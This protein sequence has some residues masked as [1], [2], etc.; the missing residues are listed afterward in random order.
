[1]PKFY[2]VEVARDIRIFKTVSV[3]VPDGLKDEDV[4]AFLEEHLT[5]G[6]HDDIVDAYD[7]GYTEDSGTLEIVDAADAANPKDFED[8]SDADIDLSDEYVDEEDE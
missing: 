2:N 6:D 4:D 5:S 8:A 3:A 1:M 7:A